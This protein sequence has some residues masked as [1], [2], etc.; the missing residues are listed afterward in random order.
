MTLS[1]MIL[2]L[3]E[4]TNLALLAHTSCFSD[5]VAPVAVP[6]VI[7]GVTSVRDDC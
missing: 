5:Q 2:Q 7:Y 6:A 1:V 3:Q 4:F